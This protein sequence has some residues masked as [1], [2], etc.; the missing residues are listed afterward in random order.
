MQ[1][2]FSRVQK[3][4]VLLVGMFDSI[5]FARWIS[6]F[7]GGD[8]QF[9]IYPSSKFRKMHPLLEEVLSFNDLCTIEIPFLDRFVPKSLLGYLDFMLFCV[10]ALLFRKLNFRAKLLSRALKKN[11]FSFVHLLEFQHAGYLY[12]D[13]EI[14]SKLDKDYKLIATN[15]G[16]DIFFFQ[17]DLSHRNR[18][19]R[20]LQL[21]D[22]YSAECERD[23]KL[24]KDMGFVGEFLP[25]IPNAGGFKENLFILPP[26]SER[27][28]IICKAYGGLFGRGDLL[29][30]VL[31]E[32]LV[33]FPD[34]PVFLY[35]VTDDLLGNV[36]N[37]ASKYPSVQFSDQNHK[38]A[39]PALLEKFRSAQIY[40][41]LS[42]SDGI[43][44]SFLE[45]LSSGAYPIQSNTSCAQEWVKK[46]A[47]ASIVPLKKNEILQEL[48][49][50]YNNFQKL[51]ASQRENISVA[52][53]YLN[54]EV[55]AR[56]GKDFYS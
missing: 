12:L 40:I 23:Y 15:W 44:T 6:Q 21:A 34:T 8:I 13:A 52:K 32:F 11:D 36:S 4:K 31:E 48:K 54:Y 45:A 42:R 27:N 37:L 17:D 47:V 41:G 51:A 18:I 2:D 26:P 5:H 33:D 49:C 53:K 16:S 56:I 20:L 25:C 35:S 43:S 19:Q 28:L 10:P 1:S 22:L 55:I 30:E 46:G 9:L 39:H 3:Q 14:S 7:K 29:I 38:L 50:T 24:A